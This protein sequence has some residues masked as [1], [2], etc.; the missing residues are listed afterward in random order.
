MYFSPWPWSLHRA[1][2]PKICS[3]NFEV[4]RSGIKN[5]RGGKMYIYWGKHK[6][7]PRK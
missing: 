4:Q 1:F 7:L 6:Y 2:I 5:R 3:M